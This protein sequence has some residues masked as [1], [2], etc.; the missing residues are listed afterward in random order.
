MAS[1]STIVIHLT[2]AELQQHGWTLLTLLRK[3]SQFEPTAA[4]TRIP[5]VMC[6]DHNDGYHVS[7]VLTDG[8]VNAEQPDLTSPGAAS[9]APNIPPPASLAVTVPTV[10][11]VISSLSILARA[12]PD[13]VGAKAGNP[14]MCRFSPYCQMLNFKEQDTGNPPINFVGRHRGYAATSF[15]R[16]IPV[17]LRFGDNS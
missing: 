14:I 13:P 9:H 3:S 7:C 6:H 2:V 10:A 5:F 4:N 1:G 12:L 8:P 16:A 15:R 11:D 17:W